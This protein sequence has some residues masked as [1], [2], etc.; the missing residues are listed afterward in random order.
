MNTRIL[1][2]SGLASLVLLLIFGFCFAAGAQVTIRTTWQVPQGK[3]DKADQMWLAF[4]DAAQG[5][6]SGTQFAIIWRQDTSGWFPVWKLSLIG[7]PE[8]MPAG[9]TT[10]PQGEGQVRADIA[11]LP[12]PTTNHTYAVTLAY[13]RDN[14]AMGIAVTDQTAGREL[15]AIG[16][17]VAPE[18]DL[19]AP[20]SGGIMAGQTLTAPSTTQPYFTPL[21]VSWQF[22]RVAPGGAPAYMG[23]DPV[24]EA[25][26]RIELELHLPTDAR[27]AWTV[28][29][30]TPQAEVPLATVPG[31]R[32]RHTVAVLDVSQELVGRQQLVLRYEDDGVVA[33]SY[34]Q[35]FRGGRV[36]VRIA[37]PTIDAATQTIS[38]NVQIT[39]TV[40]VALN[41]S[42]HAKLS[43]IAWNPSSLRYEE[44]EV[45]VIHDAP[46]TPVDFAR[47]PGPV[48]V[49]MRFAGPTQPGTY[50]LRYQVDHDLDP[51][52]AFAA[53]GGGHVL[54]IHDSQVQFTVATYNLWATTLWPAREPAL[55]AV[56]KQM[57]PDIIAL[58]ELRPQTRA[59]LDDALP[60]HARV[61]DSFYGWATEGNIYWSTELF[62]LVEHGAHDIGIYETYRR[63]FWVRL[64]VKQTGATLL[65]ST[66]HYTW[67][68]HARIKAE[69]GRPRLEM[70]ARTVAALDQLRQDGEPVIFMGDLNES[71]EAINILRIGG[72]IDSVGSRGEP[73][74]PTHPADAGMSAR[75]ILDWQLYQ[76]PLTILDSQ[77]V[78][79]FF[80][81]MAPSDHKPVLVTYGM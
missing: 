66:A 74:Q 36:A 24:V 25:G 43:Q 2:R 48:D 71:G 52:I 45:A 37:P 31:E 76:G 39:S 55:R 6:H 57:Q 22:R 49:E 80:E 70:A 1:R 10:V 35:S 20:T 72:L 16:L 63:L 44:T 27:G 19:T 3:L 46:S 53:D 7:L 79:F 73:L 9:Y 51:D 41:L 17:S 28:Y 42:I 29:L 4:G 75:L 47:H 26:D 33:Q 65:V 60:H 18:L 81:G 14:G 23:P 67:D 15:M 62:E 34:S 77:V 78:D 50:K 5:L 30:Q 40:P 64:R 8:H 12:A 68:G 69:G 54:I 59:V 21:G 38:A 13:D 32:G 56:L 11:T 58:Q 61:T